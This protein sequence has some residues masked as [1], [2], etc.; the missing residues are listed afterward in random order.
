MEIKQMRKTRKNIY[1]GLV[2][3]AIALLAGLLAGLMAVQR[4]SFRLEN[5]AQDAMYQKAGVLPDDI[6]IITIDEATLAELG[7]Y[8]NWNRRYFAE[9]L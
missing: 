8:S 3:G 4:V 7:P 6:K 5:M 9:L 1:T 2:A